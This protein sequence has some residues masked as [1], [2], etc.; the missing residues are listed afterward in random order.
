MVLSL[1]AT[2]DG[3]RVSGRLWFFGALPAGDCRFCARYKGRAVHGSLLWGAVKRPTRP[4]K[5]ALPTQSHAVS[6]P[7]WG[8]G[9]LLT[10]GLV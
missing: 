5:V 3:E 2:F 6:C 7:L 8:G 9:D 4:S 10:T 1:P